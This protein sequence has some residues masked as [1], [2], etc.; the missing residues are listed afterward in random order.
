MNEIEAESILGQELSRYR[1]RS[2]SELLSEVGRRETFERA[3]PSGVTYQIEVQVFFD[4]ESRR[5]LR[6]MGAID[7]GGWRALS[8]LCDDFIMALDG[9]FVGE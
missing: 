7:N 4:D 6:V 1:R 5:T 2:Y 9:L 8:P 3:S